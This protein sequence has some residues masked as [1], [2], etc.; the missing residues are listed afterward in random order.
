LDASSLLNVGKTFHE[1]IEA[2]ST[3]AH[4]STV[5][6]DC[7]SAHVAKDPEPFVLDGER[8]MRDINAVESN[9]KARMMI[10]TNF[11]TKPLCVDIDYDEKSKTIESIFL[12]IIFNRNN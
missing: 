8:Y 6:H 10:I 5:T 12:R 2:V 7:T 9:K 3:V 11:L 4:E 1:S